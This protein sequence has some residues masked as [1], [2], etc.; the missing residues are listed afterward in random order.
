MLRILSFTESIQRQLSGVSLLPTFKILK[1][2]WEL[3]SLSRLSFTTTT[4][5]AT[6]A[7]RLIAISLSLSLN[8]C[9]GQC[10][11]TLPVLNWRS[12][13]PSF[14]QLFSEGYCFSD[15]ISDTTLCYRFNPDGFLGHFRWGF[16][17][18]L[19]FNLDVTDITT[20]DT[21]CTIVNVG[22][23]FPNTT[24]S[25]SDHTV[26]FTLRT[27]YIDN[28]CPYFAP[29]SGL[30]VEFGEI[31]V[32][33]LGLTITTNWFTYSETNS[34]EFHIQL[35]SDLINYTTVAKKK[36]VGNSSSQS[37]YSVSFESPFYETVYLR[38]AEVDL[39]G[40]VSYSDPIVFYHLPNV[41]R[42]V[43]RFGDYDIVGRKVR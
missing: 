39:N 37:D 32:E 6:S 2:L 3:S 16:S 29:F 28:F 26:C 11:T 30:A 15:S 33:Q 24:F 36:S 25:T 10:D 43:D 38:I 42:Q 35:S 17:S 5:F 4:V 31:T 1:S 34:Y 27:E 22:N 8:V 41:I 14:I 23:F 7:R 20:Y 21:S 18:P 19:G 12:N 13:N 9:V 40:D